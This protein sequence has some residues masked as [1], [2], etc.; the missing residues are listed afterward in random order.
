MIVDWEEVKMRKAT[1][2][3]TKG[4]WWVME[5]DW[6]GQVYCTIPVTETGISEQRLQALLVYIDSSA[7]PNNHGQGASL[8]LQ[9]GVIGEKVRGGMGGGRLE[10]EVWF[11]RS[12]PLNV[13][14]AAAMGLGG[15]ARCCR[16]GKSEPLVDSD[17][18][19]RSFLALARGQ[20]AQIRREEIPAGW[21]ARQ[22]KVNQSAVVAVKWYCPDHPPK[23][24][25]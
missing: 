21:F 16:C 23:I 2:P 14:W 5:G 15:K 3:A 10:R 24:G 11:H 18:M 9:D 22:V 12:L 13:K 6:G 8:A 20:T 19:R 7:W 17:F 25:R 4:W 1:K